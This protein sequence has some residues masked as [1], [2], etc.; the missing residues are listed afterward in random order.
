MASTLESIP[1]KIYV[2]TKRKPAKYR[3]TYSSDLKSLAIPLVNAFMTITK[4]RGVLNA[5][6]TWKNPISL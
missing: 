6:K 2:K 5:I 3:N 1:V 4:N